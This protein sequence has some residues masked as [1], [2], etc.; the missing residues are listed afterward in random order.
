MLL[1]SAME[2]W[3][4]P[5]KAHIF[6]LS[7]A[8]SHRL[9]HYLLI[10]EE[11]QDFLLALLLF[12]FFELNDFFIFFRLKGSSAI[13]CYHCN[14]AYD[15][16]CADPFNSFS[17]GI[18]NCSTQ[19]ETEHQKS[20]GLQSTLCRKTK[21]KGEKLSVLKMYSKC[22]LKHRLVDKNQF[23]FMESS[24][25]FAAAA[26]SQTSETTKT[27]WSVV[28]LTMSKHFIAHAQLTCA[29]HHPKCSILVRLFFPFSVSR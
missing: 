8:F 10:S 24:V 19:Q 15:P 2:K 4:N 6:F 27:A 26:T 29:T 20:L 12:L 9:Q 25:S 21:Q 28:E 3:S 14:S 23:Q 17:I 1:L 5:I 11:F 7:S 13:M 16:R 22:W 18:I